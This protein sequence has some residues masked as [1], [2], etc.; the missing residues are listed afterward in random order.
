MNDLAP[1]Q[2]GPKRLSIR[3]EDFDVLIENGSF[4]GMSKV[5]LIEGELLVMSPQHLPHARTKTE[6]GFRIHAAL[7]AIGSPYVAIIEGTVSIPPI[8]APEP[9]IVLTSQPDG[10]LGIPIGSVPLV[11]EVSASTLDYDL[12]RKAMIYARAAVP[13]YWI[14]S[15][16]GRTILRFTAPGEDGYLERFDVP[17]DTPITAATIPGLTIDTTG[18]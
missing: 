8:N 11:V 13:E 3:V 16:E 1:L 7:K 5:E 12:G 14:V 17:F 6:L 9:D 15:I 10:R 18:L 2:T 4:E